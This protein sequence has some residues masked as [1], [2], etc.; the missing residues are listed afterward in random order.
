M[1][2]TGAKGGLVNMTQICCMLGQQ[3]L[4][5]RRVPKMQNGKTLPCYLPHD[6]NPRSSGYVTDRFISGLRPQDF[7]F[8]C[9][10]GR[11]GLIDTAVKTSRSGYLQ[12]CLIKQLESLIVNYDMTVRDNDGSII[13]FLYGEDAIDVMNTKFLEKFNFLE[14]NFTSLITNY[15]GG[16]IMQRVNSVAIDEYKTKC[17]KKLKAIKR[18]QPNISNHELKKHRGEPAISLYHPLKYFGSISE[19]MESKLK[20]YVETESLAKL[21][22]I[23]GDKALKAKFKP[24]KSETFRKMYFLKYMRSVVHPGENVGTLAG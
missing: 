15:N 1:V 19:K 9:M 21:R 12:R 24:I 5:G 18:E 8:H 20:H 3:E 17:K 2:L 13:Q 23:L 16:E 10:A 22:E 14:Q 6:P 7:F 11:E 4:E